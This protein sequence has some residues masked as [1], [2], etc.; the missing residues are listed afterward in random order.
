[1]ELQRRQQL[2]MN[3]NKIWNQ[4]L[5]FLDFPSSAVQIS[6]LKAIPS[7]L[8]SAAT[9]KTSLPSQKTY[10][11]LVIRVFDSFSEHNLYIDDA[12]TMPRLLFARQGALNMK[13]VVS[14]MKANIETFTTVI[15]SSRSVGDE[16]E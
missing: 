7:M 1:M 10:S 15:F 12:P 3:R 9:Q 4:M 16:E 2:P 5:R 13:D 11:D 8:E 6:T 14:R